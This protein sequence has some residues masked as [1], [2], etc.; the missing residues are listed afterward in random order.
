MNN[1]SEMGEKRYKILKPLLVDVIDTTSVETTQDLYDK[2]RE[3]LKDQMCIQKK[4][5][6]YFGFTTRR[7][8]LENADAGH[9]SYNVVE[10][11]SYEE[12]IERFNREVAR[13]ELTGF[14]LRFA[15]YYGAGD[16]NCFIVVCN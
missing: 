3:I 12:L 7:D 5:C 4:V 9:Y 10:Y 16:E 1:F 6:T 8:E 14:R 2:V 15:T 13:Y 11:Y